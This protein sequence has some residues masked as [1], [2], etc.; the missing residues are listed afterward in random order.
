MHEPP[1]PPP[2]PRQPWLTWDEREDFEDYLS[3]NVEGLTRLRDA[4]D[5]ALEHGQAPLGPTRAFFSVNG[6]L[7]VDGDPR[8]AYVPTKRTVGALMW[9]LFCAALGMLAIVGGTALL[10]VLFTLLVRY[11]KYLLAGQ[12]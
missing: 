12:A 8:E 6:V 2:D 1:K 4:I 9:V 5:A 10:V 7:R 11:L 3:G